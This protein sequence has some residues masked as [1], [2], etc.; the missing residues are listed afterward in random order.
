ML[1]LEDESRDEWPNIARI[2]AEMETLE[3]VLCAY[4]G[5]S[6]QTPVG[7]FQPLGDAH[8][9]QPVSDDRDAE[10][11]LQSAR[12]PVDASLLATLEEHVHDLEEWGEAFILCRPRRWEFV[13]ASIPHK[14]MIL[15]HEEFGSSI[16]A[17]GYRLSDDEPDWW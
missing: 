8:P 5:E 2:L 11:S 13:A 6:F 3:M 16:A 9:V 7:P 1:Y 12:V 10:T 17:A 4:P 15:I 14:G